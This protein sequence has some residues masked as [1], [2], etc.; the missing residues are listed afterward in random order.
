MSDQAESVF[1]AIGGEPTFRALVDEFY[2]RVEADPE[3]RAIFPE[4]MEPGKYHQYLFLMQYWGGPP[5]YMSERGHPR[6]RLRHAPYGITPDLSNRWV[7]HMHSAIDV[8][9]IQEPYRSQMREYFESGAT[10][11]INRYQSESD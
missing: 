10:F 1:D 4:D 9:G 2:R 6:M 5:I 3:L 7:T 11:L 8:V